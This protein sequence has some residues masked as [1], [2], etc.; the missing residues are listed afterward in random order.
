MQYIKEKHRQFE[1]N[2]LLYQMTAGASA[3]ISAGEK[4]PEKSAEETAPAPEVKDPQKT[5][6]DEIAQKYSPETYEADIRKS[7]KNEDLIKRSVENYS[8]VYKT[9][10]TDYFT[11][12]DKLYAD[13]EAAIEKVQSKTKQELDLLRGAITKGA[14]AKE[15]GNEAEKI[16]EDFSSWIDGQKDVLKYPKKDEVMDKFENYIN[17]MNDYYLNPV[18]QKAR[19]TKFGDRTWGIPIIYPNFERNKV[20]EYYEKKS[21]VFRERMKEKTKANLE[22]MLSVKTTDKEA[23]KTFRK[24][25]EYEYVKYSGLD[26]RPGVIDVED[27]ARME[28][29]TLP[30]LDILSKMNTSGENADRNML[31]AMQLMNPDAWESAIYRDNERTWGIPIIYP[32][33][34]K[35]K[36]RNIKNIIISDAINNGTQS[37]FIEAANSWRKK[38]EGETKPLENFSEAQDYFK[39]MIEIYAKMGVDKT[40]EFIMHFNNI[41]NKKRISILESVSP[42][43]LRE[44]VSRERDLLLARVSIPQ[45]PGDRLIVE[46]VSTGPE[47]RKKILAE[48]GDELFREIKN[49]Q[50]HYQKTYE[51]TYGR[52]ASKTV[53]QEA[54]RLQAM[55]MISNEAEW[56]IGNIDKKRAVK[57]NGTTADKEP[58]HAGLKFTD[59]RESKSVP[60]RSSL[61]RGGFNGHDLALTGLKVLGVLTVIANVG[62]S[63]GAAEGPDLFSKAESAIGNMATNP[64]LFAG[65]TAAFGAHTLQRN[66][67]I[68]TYI[69]E[70]A[71]GRLEKSATRRLRSL[72]DRAGVSHLKN[73]VSNNSEWKAMHQLESEQIKDLMKEAS[74]RK[75]KPPRITKED[76]SKIITDKEILVGIPEDL[77]NAHLRYRFYQKFLMEREKPN[78]RELQEICQKNKIVS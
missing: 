48:R 26:G 38:E 62:N 54:V 65:L 23:L 11:K 67:E 70:S 75:E 35:P 3:E 72:A 51:D 15:R 36:P 5:W 66:P 4:A 50:T 19:L 10:E 30:K 20:F 25:I 44:P 71:Y 68:E 31:E 12:S 28:K 73:F 40:K 2:R 41:V 59:V 18:W 49:V 64:G 33:S 42:E 60:Y 39:K 21:D 63:I 56:I 74:E 55:I 69:G 7:F 57:L 22:Y 29:D 45:R 14:E 17:A 78:T 6:E 34:E 13:K 76:L 58:I 47:D 16:G 77:N 32:N 8:K 27:L 37:L 61:Y 43:S 52:T 1:I 24:R 9:A 53:S 46:F